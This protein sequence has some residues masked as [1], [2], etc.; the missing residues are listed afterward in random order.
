[1]ALVAILDNSLIA[2]YQHS[3]FQAGGSHQETI[4]RIIRRGKRSN[5]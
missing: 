1:M 4:R 2:R 3:V 5:D